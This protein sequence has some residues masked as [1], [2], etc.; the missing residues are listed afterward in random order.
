MSFEYTWKVYAGDT[1]YS[2]RIY[3]P[4]VIDYVIRTLQEFR[5]AVGF[6]NERFQREGFIP[7][8]RNIDVNYLAPIRVDDV[9]TITLDPSV[10]TTSMTYD[11]SGTTDRD[12]AVE[13]ALTTVF[14]DS[15]RRLNTSS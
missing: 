15:E 5:E 13:G 11:L 6:S 12:R 10:G 2:G 9:L 14:V 3:T 4:A 8:A 7:P 1:D